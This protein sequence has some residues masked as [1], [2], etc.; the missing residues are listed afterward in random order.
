MDEDKRRKRQIIGNLLR[1]LRIKI[2][3]L[4]KHSIFHVL[5]SH[6]FGKEG[7]AITGQKIKEI[8]SKGGRNQESFTIETFLICL[9][10]IQAFSVERF[11]IIFDKKFLMHESAD[12]ENFSRETLHDLIESYLNRSNNLFYAV[13]PFQDLSKRWG[14]LIVGVY[15]KMEIKIAKLIVITEDPDHVPLQVTT[16]IVQLL[17]QNEFEHQVQWVNKGFEEPHGDFQLFLQ[18]LAIVNRNYYEP[19][20]KD[21][22]LVHLIPEVFKL[23]KDEIFDSGEESEPDRTKKKKNRQ[24]KNRRRRLNVNS[25]IRKQRKEE[26]KAMIEGVENISLTS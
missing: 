21:I 12:L 1:N 19:V 16:P 3:S 2:D 24:N 25:S 7:M 10:A 6:S 18:I 13:L 8:L 22:F 9:N 20:E 26:K 14:C 15:T 11:H 5:K 4:D 23:K 17:E